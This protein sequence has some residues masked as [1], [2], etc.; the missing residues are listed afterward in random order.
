MSHVATIT[1]TPVTDGLPPNNQKVLACY[2]NQAGMARVVVARWVAARSREVREIDDFDMDYD[3][4][5]DTYYWPEGWYEWVDN[6]DD[7]GAILIYEGE[8]T[9]W[10]SLAEVL[11]I[12]RTI[13]GGAA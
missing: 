12:Y 11:S 6:D 5:A 13:T 2:R 8:V 3:E 7:H 1:L 4:Q 9:H 10:G